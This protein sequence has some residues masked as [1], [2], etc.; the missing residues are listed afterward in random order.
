MRDSKLPLRAHH[1]STVDAVAV[2]PNEVLS[3]IAYLTDICFT[4]PQINELFLVLDTDGNGEISKEEFLTGFYKFV[5]GV[6]EIRPCVVQSHMQ[7]ISCRNA[8]TTRCATA[9]C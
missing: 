9:V 4:S 1:N 5:G 6:S 3:I 2:D 7:F 8:V